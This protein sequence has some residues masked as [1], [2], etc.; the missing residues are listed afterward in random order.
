MICKSHHLFLKE[1]SKLKGI[2]TS[3]GYSNMFFDRMYKS[4]ILRNEHAT[5]SDK[6][7]VNFKHML[8]IPFVGQVSFKSKIMILFLSE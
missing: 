8:K 4:F 2:F 5:T 1:V 7:E 3:N 6:N